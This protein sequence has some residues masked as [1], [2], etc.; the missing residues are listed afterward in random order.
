MAL[1]F[2][3]NDITKVKA[4]AIVLPANKI[5]EQGDGASRS[6]FVA[7]CEQKLKGELSVVHDNDCEI[8]KAVATFGNDLGHGVK[9]IIHAVCPQ[10]L[11][12]EYGEEEFLYSAYK[13]SLILA[14]Q[15]KCRSIAFPLLSTGSNRFPRPEALKI[16][17]NAIL[18][19][20]TDNEMDIYL[21]F[22]GQD[23]MR[24]GSRFFG[25]I[26]EYI[27]DDYA[28]SVD[29]RIRPMERRKLMARGID[30]YGQKEAFEALQKA[31][32]DTPPLVD[33]LE[34]AES[35]ETFHDM[36]LRLISNS[37]MS[38]PMIYEKARITKQHYSKI[39]NKQNY[40]PKKET[41]LALAFA[42]NLTTKE[43]NELLMKAGYVLCDSDKY[44]V[45]IKYCLDRRK[46]DLH[47]VNEFL[48][49]RGLQDRTFNYKKK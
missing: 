27:D 10:W 15:K 20:L 45:I 21:V 6:I 3:R 48:R 14:K 8:G 7:A 26:K 40:T 17:I 32:I 39:K 37:G 9:Y 43:T 4:D 5:L 16:A 31:P 23:G 29:N 35:A 38:D 1:R 19:F 30:V 44:D 24:D 46:T 28:D 2:I 11:G 34:N 13:E 49:G 33:L 25:D 36:I 22:F 18:D 47:E 42:L 12:G 41:I